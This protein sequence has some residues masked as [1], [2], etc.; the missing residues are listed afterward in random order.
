M[1]VLLDDGYGPYVAAAKLQLTGSGTYEILQ[2]YGADPTSD[3]CQTIVLLDTSGDVVYEPDYQHLMEVEIDRDGKHLFVLNRHTLNNNTRILVY[4]TSDDSQPVAVCDVNLAAP[5]AMVV[6]SVEE[7]LYLVSSPEPNDSPAPDVHCFSVDTAGPDKGLTY[8]GCIS[9]MFPQPDVDMGL[10]SIAA[11][12][13]MTENRAD[14]TLYVAGFTAPKL[15]DDEPIK[16]TLGQVFPGLPEIFTT[17]V[18]AVIPVDSTSVEAKAIGGSD[19][20][21]ALPL[22]VAWTGAAD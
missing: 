16:R 19:P 12:T 10:G 13:S 11:I 9:I 1:P 22:S 5:A 3:P 8:E 17:P 2:L 14:G 21:L 15:P 7:K 6:S 4:D 20:S 18:L